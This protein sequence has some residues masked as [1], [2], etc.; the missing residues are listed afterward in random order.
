MK[1]YAV[2]IN[3]DVNHEL[4]RHLLAR[5]NQEDLCFAV[6][7]PSIG[8]QRI[9]A[10]L[11]AVILPLHSDREL[12]G[13]VSF[14]PA[15]LERA[16]AT[17]ARCNGGLA[18]LHS[19]VGAGWQDMSTDDVAAEHRM[20]AA[21]LSVTGFP[22]VGLTAGTD[23]AWS[24][25]HWIKDPAEKWKY[26]RRWCEVVK[27]I[28]KSLSVTFCDQQLKPRINERTQLRTI[29]AWGQAKQEDLSRLRVV[30]VGLGSVGSMVAEIL[31]RIGITRFTLI[32]HD[33]VEEKNLDR[34]A[35]VFA[36]DIGRSKVSA[37]AEAIR[38]SSS[39]SVIDITPVQYSICEEQGFSASLDSDVI[40]SCVDR[41]WP[42]Q[43]MNFISYAHLIPVI[44]G[45]ILVRT[46][47]DNTRIKGAD[48]RSH[49]V[50]HSHMCL[51]CIGQYTAEYAKLERDG[52]VDDPLYM[53]DYRGPQID[54]HENVFA[55]S[56]HLASSLVLHLLSC[57]VAPAG[58][59]NVGAQIYHFATGTLDVE[60]NN[61]C[62]ANCFFRTIMGK[63]HYSGVV[64]TA[65]HPAAEAKRTER[66]WAAWNHVSNQ[67]RTK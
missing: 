45:G 10:I 18:F 63:T 21:A 42:R 34:L 11:Q 64:V 30:I 3:Q 61:D 25:R 33:T 28:G 50:G 12:H 35:N 38:R 24:A 67:T 52:Y 22:L 49:V 59:P 19:H 37:V 4:L 36:S 66:F 8:D 40:F 60:H 2:A 5:E 26:S 9:T 13:N 47:A 17:A 29:S 65:R 55:F 15:Y 32:D 44:D 48:W 58:I 57:F 1:E 43:V 7:L 20:A 53:K 39:A 54:V 62:K 16:L 6:Y 23:G 46:N 56:S 27:V 14:K 51:E 31:A 41:P